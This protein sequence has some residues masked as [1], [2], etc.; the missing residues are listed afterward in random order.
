M[1]DP[2]N[3]QP[4]NSLTLPPSLFLVIKSEAWLEAGSEDTADKGHFYGWQ[5]KASFEEL[6]CNFPSYPKCPKEVRE[7]QL[8]QF[9]SLG[10]Y[11]SF[12]EGA[13]KAYL[14]L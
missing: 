12:G 5:E 1:G 7:D 8:S 9:P 6:L 13:E 10:D 14:T 3:N 4:T 2:H 11:Y